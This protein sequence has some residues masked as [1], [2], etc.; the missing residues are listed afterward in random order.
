MLLT[1]PSCKKP[2]PVRVW[3]G[4]K[5]ARWIERETGKSQVHNQRGWD[6]LKK[7]DYSWQRPRPKHR[8]RCPQAQTEF[9]ENL[10]KKVKDIQK[11]YP[12]AQVEVLFFD[13]HRVGLRPILAKVWSPRHQGPTAIV[14]SSR[15]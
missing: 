14:R 8:K 13:E 6:Y 4:P 9:K 2:T 10:P 12:Y 11:R 3:T 7:L 5:V 15:I 1:P